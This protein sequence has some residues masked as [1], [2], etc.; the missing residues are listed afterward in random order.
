VQYLD[1]IDQHEADRMDGKQKNISSGFGGK[2]APK[3]INGM[4]NP[5]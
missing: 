3:Q 1:Y 5:K 2:I 4:E